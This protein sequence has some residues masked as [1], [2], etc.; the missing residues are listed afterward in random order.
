MLVKLFG[1]ILQPIHKYEQSQPNEV[2]E[3]PIPSNSLKSKMML[4]GKMPLNSTIENNDQHSHT[5]RHMHSMKT[6][7]HIKSRTIRT[8]T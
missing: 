5:Q 7:Q 6:C 3:V 2:D 1:S 4:R 8:R